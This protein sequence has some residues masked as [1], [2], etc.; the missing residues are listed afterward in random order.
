MI[1]LSELTA[2]ARRATEELLEAAH[3]ETGDIFVVGCSSSEIRGG[4]IGHDSSMEVA[5]AVLAGVLPPL[6]EQGVY[7]AAQCCEHLNRSIV[8]E[9][10]V[11][12]QYGCQIVAAI[13]QPH[14]G[15]SWATNCWRTFK[16]PVLVEEVK[17]AAGMDIGGTLIGM[18]LRRVAVPVRLSMDHI[19]EAILLCART[20]PPFIGGSRAV[21]SDTEVR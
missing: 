13:P 14:A 7:L 10:E 4:R 17:A 18:H 19:G 11:A 6:Q 21:Y 8:I 15:G 12:K 9:R 3:L 2:Q 20:R 16:D 5:A 1:E